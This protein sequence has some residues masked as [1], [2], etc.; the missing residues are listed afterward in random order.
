MPYSHLL[1]AKG[2]LDG[3]PRNVV[4]LFESSTELGG[5]GFGADLNENDGGRY[6]WGVLAVAGLRNSTIGRRADSAD[7]EVI[8]LNSSLRRRFLLTLAS[9]PLENGF[10]A[11][12][13]PSHLKRKLLPSLTLWGT[14]CAKLKILSSV[15][16]S[17]RNSSKD[18]SKPTM[19]TCTNGSL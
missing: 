13:T 6:G 14:S 18:L 3:R 10:K 5:G 11:L 4:G 1:L 8:T 9:R 17:S 16:S 12:H 7:L 19:M 15:S 2:D